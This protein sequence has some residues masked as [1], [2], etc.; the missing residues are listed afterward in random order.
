M[1]SDYTKK[2]T[3]LNITRFIGE[4]LDFSC[5]KTILQRFRI[6]LISSGVFRCL[7]QLQS[8]SLRLLLVQAIIS[9]IYLQSE[10]DKRE[11]RINS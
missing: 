10:T 7:V 1:Y 4:Y 9:L 8:F 6:V 3:G 2:Y 11:W 5:S